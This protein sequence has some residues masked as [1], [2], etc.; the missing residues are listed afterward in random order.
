MGAKHAQSFIE[1]GLIRADHSALDS[2]HVMRV[3]KGKVR[4]KSEGP[5]FLFPVSCAV[6]LADIFDQWHMLRLKSRQEIGVQGSV[7]ENMRQ[8]D[9]FRSRR[10]FLQHLTRV[11]AESPGVDV[12]EYRCKATL[13]DRRD[14]GHPGE[15]RHDDFARAVSFF[16]G[17]DRQKVGRRSRVDQDTEVYSKPTRPFLLERFDLV[18]LRQYRQFGPKEIDDRFDI[19]SKDVIAHQRPIEIFGAA[20]EIRTAL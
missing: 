20:H 8:E 3:I 7:P 15:S 18:G 10:D 1:P 4:H 17:G 6:G 13:N 2:A 9:R 12:D 5:E 11:H 14:I 16:Q 19:R